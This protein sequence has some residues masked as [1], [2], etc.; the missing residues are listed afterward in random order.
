MEEWR[1]GGI[2]RLDC[3]IM[4]VELEKWNCFTVNWAVR[5][6]R[7]N[8]LWNIWNIENAHTHKG[9]REK[10]EEWEKGMRVEM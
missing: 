6:E 8:G 10:N 3:K 1:E 4:N 2:R 9:G 5:E 7:G